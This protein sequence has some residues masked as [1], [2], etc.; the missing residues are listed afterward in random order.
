MKTLS[1]AAML[2]ASF[3]A[4][5]IAQPQH[6]QSKTAPQVQ[7]DA[8]WARHYAP[9]CSANSQNCGFA[10]GIIWDPHFLA[11][12]RHSLPQSESW[13]VN[14]HRSHSSVTNVV[15]EFLGI[16]ESSSFDDNRYLTVAGC[17]PHV[18]TVKGMIW[19]DTGTNPSTVLFVAEDAATGRNAGYRL[20]LYSSKPMNLGALPSDFL[21]SLTHW[22]TAIAATAPSYFPQTIALVTLVQ[23][24]G[25]ERDLTWDELIGATNHPPSSN[26]GAKP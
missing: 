3:A 20:W 1:I 14:D 12:L 11:L 25:L 23:P 24:N 17:V 6:T 4:S 13:W 22:H 19:I 10:G 26:T 5:C 9:D 8:E 15:L 16:P 21:S 18:C 2:L 7:T